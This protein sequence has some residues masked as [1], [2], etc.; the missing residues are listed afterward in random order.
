MH[1][2]ISAHLYDQNK[3]VNI[4]KSKLTKKTITD[5]HEDDSV[6]KIK[7]FAK[8]HLQNKHFFAYYFLTKYLLTKCR[9]FQTVDIMVSSELG[10]W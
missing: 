8:V 10:I 3:A 4:Q 7:N 9:P 6:L 2:L 1:I 5:L